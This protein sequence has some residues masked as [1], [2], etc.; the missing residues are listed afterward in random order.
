MD[1]QRGGS[2]MSLKPKP[3]KSQPLGV[4]FTKIVQRLQGATLPKYS[5]LCS[6]DKQKVLHFYTPPP[7]QKP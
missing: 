2:F 4:C 5:I 1:L 6:T 7:K 3:Y